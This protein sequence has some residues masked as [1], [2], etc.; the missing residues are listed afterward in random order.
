[1]V[2]RLPSEEICNEYAAQTMFCQ[3]QAF[4]TEKNKEKARV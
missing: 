2:I 4:Q 1:M 3:H